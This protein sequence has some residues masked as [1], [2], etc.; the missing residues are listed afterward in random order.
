MCIRD[1]KYPMDTDR[2]DIKSLVHLKGIK[3]KQINDISD[4]TNIR[5]GKG[6]QAKKV[7]EIQQLHAGVCK[8]DQQ[9]KRDQMMSAQQHQSILGYSSL[10]SQL[11]QTRSTSCKFN[12]SFQAYHMDA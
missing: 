3:G 12:T 2:I 9:D 6:S 5:L 11:S 1:S 8:F 7:V 10:L 4:Y